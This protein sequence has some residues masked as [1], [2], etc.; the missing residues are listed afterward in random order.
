MG[1]IGLYEK[2]LVNALIKEK[3]D[4][5]TQVKDGYKTIDISIPWAKL[6]IEVDGK[7][8]YIDG[9]QMISDLKRSYWSSR[10]GYQTLHIPNELIKTNCIE[11]AKAIKKLAYNRLNEMRT[12]RKYIKND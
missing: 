1:N 5:K 7:Q 3:L 12:N 4:I 2:K 11:I 9:E 8:H 6:D 10:S